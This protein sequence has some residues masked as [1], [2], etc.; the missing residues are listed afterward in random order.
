MDVYQQNGYANRAEYLKTLAEDYG[1]GLRFVKEVADT[2]GADEDFDALPCYLDNGA[3]L[4]NEENG[5]FGM[6]A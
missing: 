1:L 3:E 5:Q 2:L 6:G 4:W